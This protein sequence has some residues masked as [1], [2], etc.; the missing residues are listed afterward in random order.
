MQVKART[1]TTAGQKYWLRLS[2]LTTVSGPPTGS[3][4]SMPLDFLSSY[5]QDMLKASDDHQGGVTYFYKKIDNPNSWQTKI[6]MIH[7]LLFMPPAYSKSS[8]NRCQTE[9]AIIH[10]PFFKFFVAPVIVPNP[11]LIILPLFIFPMQ[12]DID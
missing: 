8:S 1:P 10:F 7:F 12:Y 3:L 6:A 4:N 2:P 5:L 11:S 9:I